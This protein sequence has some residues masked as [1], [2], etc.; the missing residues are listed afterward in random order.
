MRL[1]NGTKDAK[2]MQ[3]GMQRHLFSVH[4]VH[5]RGIHHAMWLSKEVK[6]AMAQ[7]LAGGRLRGRRGKR[8]FKLCGTQA[9]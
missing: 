7:D 2:W 3:P 6:A 8:E 9:L 4:A 1:R 5:S